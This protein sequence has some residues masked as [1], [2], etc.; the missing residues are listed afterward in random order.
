MTQTGLNDE[1]LVVSWFGILENFSL[2]TI[3]I[4]FI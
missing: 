3:L 1:Y 4:E 2:E